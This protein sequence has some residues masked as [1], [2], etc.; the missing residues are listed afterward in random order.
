[1]ST[2]PKIS[3]RLRQIR[4]QQGLTLKQVEIKSKGRWKAVVVGSYERGTRSLSIK[5]AEELCDFYGVPLPQLFANSSEINT[6]ISTTSRPNEVWRFDLRRIRA[7]NSHPDSIVNNVH[8][9]LQN[10]AIKRDDWNGELL[11][12]R[13]SDIELLA[14]LT[15]KS[16]PDLKQALVLRGLM[17]KN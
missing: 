9:F 15:Q 11:S 17:L 12:I 5:K 16:E 10:L 14:L 4:V 6:S 8:S 3:A 1:M 7:F 2:P 13:R